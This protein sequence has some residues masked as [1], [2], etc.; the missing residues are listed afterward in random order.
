MP[1]F[2]D[3]NNKVHVIDSAEFAYLLPADCVPITDAEAGV[4]IAQQITPITLEQQISQL[5]AT[6][7][8]RRLREAVLGIDRGWLVVIN[9]QIEALHLQVEV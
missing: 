8:P 9:A 7:T 2:K 4:I 1:N 6:V 5:E 3:T